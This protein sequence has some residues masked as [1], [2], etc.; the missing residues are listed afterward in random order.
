MKSLSDAASDGS[1]LRNVGE[2]SKGTVKR[3]TTASPKKVQLRWFYFAF[4]WLLL[5]MNF[6]FRIW[7]W[8]RPSILWKRIQRRIF[9][10]KSYIFNSTKF[11]IH[12]FFLC[13][14]ACVCN[15]YNFFWIHKNWIPSYVRF[16]WQ[17]YEYNFQVKFFNFNCHFPYF[18]CFNIYLQA[19]YRFYVFISFLYFFRLSSML[20]LCI[21]LLHS[22]TRKLNRV[23]KY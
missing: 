19:F 4:Q 3:R 16:V 6:E 1:R 5:T 8:S 13:V 23:T 12:N 21:D 14:C 9:L 20:L 11:K 2:E 15:G 22:K 10:R 18:C 17:F 7:N